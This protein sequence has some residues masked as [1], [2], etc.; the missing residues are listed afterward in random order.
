MTVEAK[1]EIS[2]LA[3]LRKT[4]KK[5]VLEFRGWSEKRTPYMTIVGNP[6]IVMLHMGNLE[7]SS[8]DPH[9]FL[10]PI[11]EDEVEVYKSDLSKQFEAVIY[12]REKINE[13]NLISDRGLRISWRQTQSDDYLLL[14]PEQQSRPIQLRLGIGNG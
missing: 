14:K 11:S 6:D 3:G 9:V 5:R 1:S 12:S 7:N 4:T 8:S 10:Q 2:S 13:A